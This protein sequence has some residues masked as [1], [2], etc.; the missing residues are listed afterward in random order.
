MRVHELIST[1]SR[2]ELAELQQHLK[3][4]GDNLLTIIEGRINNLTQEHQ[5]VCANCQID[6][7][8][9]STQAFT[10]IFG[11]EDF[12]KKATFCA[13][14]CLEYFLICLKKNWGRTK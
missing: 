3:T 9:E 2:E 5:T 14:D 8:R 7:D 4:S 13:M 11:R 10:L 1:M 12:R 6:I